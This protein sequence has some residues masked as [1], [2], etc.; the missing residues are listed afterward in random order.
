MSATNKPATPERHCVRPSSL[1]Q[2]LSL[3][4]SLLISTLAAL[5][6]CSASLLLELCST[7]ICARCFLTDLTAARGQTNSNTHRGITDRWRGQPPDPTCVSP[8]TC[9]TT[10]DSGFDSRQ[11]QRL[12]APEGLQPIV[13]LLGWWLKNW[14]LRFGYAV[15]SLKRVELYL[16]IFIRLK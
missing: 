10:G 12:A 6:A 9:W 7:F 1:S 5:T 3:T 4:S 14:G 2:Y 8:S 16:H 15:P 11:K 13:E